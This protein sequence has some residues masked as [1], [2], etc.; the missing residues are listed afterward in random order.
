M[1][2]TFFGIDPD[3]CAEVLRVRRHLHCHP[4]LSHQEFTTKQ[5]LTTELLNAGVSNFTPVSDTGF[6]VDIEGNPSSGRAI[7]I[8]GDMDALPIQ[9]RT[10]LPFASCNDGIMHACGHD[11]HSAMAFGAALHFH[12]NRATFAGRVRMLFQHSEEDLPSGAYQFVEAGCMDG[13]DGVLGIHVD[14]LLPSVSVAVRP[15]VYACSSDH[16][17]IRVEGYSCHGGKPHEGVDAVAIA[18]TIVTEINRI[19]AHNTDP[20]SPLIMTV[21]MF[22]GGTACNIVSETAVLR[23]TIRAGSAGVREIAHR[24]VRRIA[25]AVAE[26][27]GGKAEVD[28]DEDAPLLTND[29]TMAELIRQ[30]TIDVGGEDRF[31]D[32][33]MW[34]ASDDFGYL[35]DVKPGVYFRLGVGNAD[36]GF[37]HPLHHP[38]FAVDEASLPLGT[39]VLVNAATRFL[40]NEAPTKRPHPKEVQTC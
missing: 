12:R 36:L 24:N 26:M 22:N 1:T 9:E 40:Q 8:R 27:H 18:A 37:T 5:V 34:T 10:G 16:F 7:A 6:Y 30:T 38:E 3:I 31:I 21:G 11:T 19:R 20:L 14:P 17:E 33:P 32:A 4:E 13:I 25:S 28:I 15:G 2:E 29:P 39:A 35:S 23:G